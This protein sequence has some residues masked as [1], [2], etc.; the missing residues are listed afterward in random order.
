MVDFEKGK[1]RERNKGK[2]THFGRQEFE[3][4]LQA[5]LI[6]NERDGNG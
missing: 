2:I 3:L 5:D 6:G 4:S 1:M